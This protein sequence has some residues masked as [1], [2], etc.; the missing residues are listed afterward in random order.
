MNK[1]EAIEKILIAK[2][3]FCSLWTKNPEYLII[4]P[5]IW[6]RCLAEFKDYDVEMFYGMKIKF[7]SGKNFI[8]VGDNYGKS[9]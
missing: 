5:D 2:N 9:N 6:F 7:V 3:D 8:M 4:S 1:K